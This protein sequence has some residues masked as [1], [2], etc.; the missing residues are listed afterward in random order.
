MAFAVK[1]LG[2]LKTARRLGADARTSSSGLSHRAVESPIQY[3][4]GFE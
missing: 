1:R 2:A 3:D 4:P